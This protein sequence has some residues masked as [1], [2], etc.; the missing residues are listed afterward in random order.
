VDCL[1]RHALDSRARPIRQCYHRKTCVIR[2]AA[3]DSIA[4]ASHSHSS[5]VYTEMA[6]LEQRVHLVHD[7]RS[8]TPA[9]GY[10]PMG[11]IFGYKKPLTD[12]LSGLH[13]TLVLLVA[14]GTSPH[15]KRAE[16]D[17]TRSKRGLRVLLRTRAG[18]SD[19]DFSG[20]RST[21]YAPLV[22]RLV[23]SG[24]PHRSSHHS[25]YA[26]GANPRR[27]SSASSTLIVGAITTHLQEGVL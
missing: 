24:V 18:Q 10:P 14:R 15:S 2:P 22:A 8:E 12:R 23:C 20:P 7:L 26:P 3:N 5:L 4:P 1:L 9:G 21:G 19:S 16:V 11:Y 25:C 17:G 13:S 6:R 27:T